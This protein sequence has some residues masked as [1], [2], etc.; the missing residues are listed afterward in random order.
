MYT[1][2]FYKSDEVRA[3]LQYAIHR[4]RTIEALFWL[5]ELDD[6]KDTSI[7]NVLFSCWFHSVGLTDL[8][9]LKKILKFEDTYNVVC[10]MSSNSIKTGGLKLHY[11]YALTDEN[12]AKIPPFKL[13]P[14]LHNKSKDLENLARVVLLHNTSSALKLS[15]NAWC[16]TWILRIAN[17]KLN[18]EQLELIT[19]LLNHKYR[20]N[21][22]VRCAIICILCMTKLE[23]STA[24]PPCT[25]LT[26]ENAMH[27][28][29]WDNCIGRKTRRV[30]A[31][32]QECLYGLTSRGK[33][34]Y[35]QTN[36][37]ELYDHDNLIKGQY[38]Y[39][40][41]IRHYGSYEAFMEDTQVYDTFMY[42]H[43]PDDIP[44]EW[45]LELQMK[46]HGIG[47]NQS[48]DTPVLRRY[49]TR[50]S[51]ISDTEKPILSKIL[52]DLQNECTSYDFESTFDRL[53]NK[54]SLS[55]DLKDSLYVQNMWA[56]KS[57]KDSLPL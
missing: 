53:Y 41:I 54:N 50:W 7:Q 17:Y 42:T 13:D 25:A 33:M 1:R 38:V 15:K 56:F 45:S 6:S 52:K 27:L 35:T 20:Y 9:I 28:D 29:N 31:I 55:K 48:I 46:S 57:L 2:H 8:G 34:T 36:I 32:P 51:T 22:Y 30:Y 37:R 10:T 26:V 24:F 19:L 23:L 4:S 3:A 44:D 16:D 43:F 14:L 11:L 5:K 21:W 39:K 12:V 18:T 47:V 49:I 40:D